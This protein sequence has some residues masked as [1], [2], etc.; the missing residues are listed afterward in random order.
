[1]TIS[2]R[3]R[4]KR[5]SSYY[6]LITI[7]QDDMTHI[8]GIACYLETKCVEGAAHGNIGSAVVYFDAK[9]KCVEHKLLFNAY[10][11]KQ[12]AEY[13]QSLSHSALRL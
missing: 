11:Q 8:L 10:K 6:S 2:G 3:S 1:M 12:I 13:L 7:A 4:L 9:L 5:H